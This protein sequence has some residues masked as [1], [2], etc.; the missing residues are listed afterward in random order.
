MA[1]FDFYMGVLSSVLI[2]CI[3][4]INN[5]A[6]TNGAFSSPT[7][8]CHVTYIIQVSNVMWHLP[9]YKVSVTCTPATTKPVIPLYELYF[10]SNVRDITKTGGPVSGYFD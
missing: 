10:V 3:Q 4:G 1:K 8:T 9:I 5:Q 7:C 2:S 6:S